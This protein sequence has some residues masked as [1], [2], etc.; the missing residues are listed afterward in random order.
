MANQI[1]HIVLAERISD[2]L[3][4]KF[5][6]H[7]FLVGTVFPDI[8]Y[9]KVIERDKTHFKGLT[10]E[11]ILNETSPFVAGM[12]YHSLVDEVREKYV[13]EKNIYQFFPASKFIKHALKTYE[14][15]IL[16]NKVSDWSEIVKYFDIIA[17]GEI[18]L[19]EQSDKLKLWHSVIQE[20]FKE[21]PTD[22]SRRG[23]V[24][25]IGFSDEIASEINGLIDKMRQIP[26]VREIILDLYNNWDS[27]VQ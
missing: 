6:R 27:L 9:L 15:E 4:K 3:F 19:V 10:L 21:S 8:R 2:Q 24:L 17:D 13:I 1:T 22:N 18:K 12:K 23:F 25:G 16:Y 5:T 26:E 14:D 20:Y 11:D 7:T